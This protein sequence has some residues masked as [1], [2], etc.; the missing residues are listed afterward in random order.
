MRFFLGFLLA[1][2]VLAQAPSVPL[3]D[4]RGVVDYF[5][6]TP[7]PA[8]VARGGILQISGTNLGPA[9][10]VTASKAPL[11]TSLGTPP[12][13][14]TLNGEA[15]PLFS[16]SANTV[17]AQVPVDASLG[18]VDILVSVGGVTGP[19]ASVTIVASQPSIRTADGSGRGVFAGTSSSTTV[20]LAVSGL[21]VTRPALDAG[22]LPPN[23]RVV[24][25]AAIISYI[26][27]V[28]VNNVAT[29]S[30]TRIGE[31]DLVLDVP[32]SAQPGDLIYLV[33]GGRPS[34][35]VVYKTLSAPVIQMSA[36]PAGSPA[37]VSLAT[38]DVSGSF[39]IPLGPKDSTGCTPAL[40]FDMISGNSG[41]L[42]SCLADPSR[43]AVSP[44]VLPPDSEVVGGLV[45]PPAGTPPAG[46]SST[47][48]IASADDDSLKTVTLSGDAS[49]LTG[50][51]DAAFLA[52]IPGPPAQTDTINGMTGAVT[53]LNGPG[54]GAG[55]AGGAGAAGGAPTS[56]TVNGLSN[57]VS[58][59]T[60]VA[61]GQF[62]MVVADDPEFPT[63][64]V[65]AVVQANGTVVASQSFPSGWLPL[66]PAKATEAGPAVLEAARLDAANKSIY[67]LARAADA[68]KDAFLIVPVDASTAPSVLPMPAGW[69]ATSCSGTIRL[70]AIALYPGDVLPGSQ[71]AETGYSNPCN[72]AGFLVLDP[73]LGTVTAY[74]SGLNSQMNATSLVNFNDFIYST[75]ADLAKRD[76]ADTVYVFDA[77]SS[78][79]YTIRLP[80]GAAT[81]G[82]VQSV[83]GTNWL[84]AAVT[85]KTAGDGGFVQ[86]DLEAATA[87]LFPIPQGF[88]NVQ[89]VSTFLATNKMAV[90]GLA[91]GTTNFQLL[92]YDL[93][94]GNV[95]VVQNPSGVAS[96][97]PPP[98]TTLAAAARLP[99]PVGNPKSNTV[100]APAYDATGNQTGVLLV[101]VP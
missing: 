6:P 20:T 79:A 100:A 55:G 70:T 1:T 73:T 23:A 36:M 5:R 51:I 97:G 86:F 42:S 63:R 81:F 95:S 90:R 29:A 50:S 35:A 77:A 31:F 41:S 99:L 58:A 11:P 49:A 69:F 61:A 34:N 48:M 84:L 21:G 67:L 89:L 22:A 40:W 59:A 76:N 2:A 13:Q 30:T 27:G 25:T 17:I 44:L 74:P 14:A 68:S 80:A 16:V 66:I 78:A 93:G 9:N 83:T 15:M 43:V 92:I 82:A 94:S 26:G 88:S 75:D 45:G 91:Q 57:I 38:P 32:A 65:Y 24:P 12:V 3:I 56:V 87:S 72:A 53:T 18:A 101:R 96:F 64:A 10:A 7:A 85:N 4:P 71:V 46:I 8:T 28:R 19:S 52:T 47:V 54:G 62:G 60:P 39:V 98:A 33:A 37:I